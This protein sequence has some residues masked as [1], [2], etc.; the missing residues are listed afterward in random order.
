MVN[1]CEL[2]DVDTYF[3]KYKLLRKIVFPTVAYGKYGS[4]TQH[5]VFSTNT[6]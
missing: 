3:G 4:K 1:E 5:D 6:V 2:C